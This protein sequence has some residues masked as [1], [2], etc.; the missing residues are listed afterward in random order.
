M[1][2][3]QKIQQLELETVKAV[4]ELRGDIKS[5]TTEVKRLSETLER[6]NETYEL[7]EDHER[8]MKAINDGLKAAIKIG[9]IRALLYSVVSAI[10]TAVIV[11]EVM[12]IVGR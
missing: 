3:D 11:Y 1:T 2:P 8:D 10:A 4:T 9:R 7:K 12:R 6:N 5:L